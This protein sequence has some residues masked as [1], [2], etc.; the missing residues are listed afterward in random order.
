MHGA[1]E[2]RRDQRRKDLAV[3][4]RFA[5]VGTLPSALFNERCPLGASW[6]FSVQPMLRPDYLPPDN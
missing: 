5:A 6:V 1:G 2:S 4:R 3:L